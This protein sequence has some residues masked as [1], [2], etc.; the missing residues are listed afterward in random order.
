MSSTVGERRRIAE[1]VE[2]VGAGSAL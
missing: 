2:G 1:V